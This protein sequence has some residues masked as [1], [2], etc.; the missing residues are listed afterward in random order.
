MTDVLAPEAAAP[1]PAQPGKAAAPGGADAAGDLGRH[2]PDQAAAAA[3]AGPPAA[4]PAIPGM[5]PVA[6]LTA[7]PAA[8]PPAP[9]PAS[10]A[11]P[12]AAAA[13]AAAAA[14]QRTFAWVGEPTAQPGAPQRNYYPAFDFCGVT[15]K[16]GEHGAGP[17]EGWRGA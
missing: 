17:R 7:A 5:V 2:Q 9:A 14:A 15:Y 4:A 16:L 10:G 3:P 1:A 8:Q 6:E 11:P 13:A 12:G